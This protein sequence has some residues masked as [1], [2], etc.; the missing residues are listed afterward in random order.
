MDTIDTGLILKNIGNFN[1]EDFD[2]RLILHKTVYVLKSFGLDLGYSYGWYL[3]GTYSP[4][5][6]KVGFE[7]Q[8]KMKKIPK[9]DVK[10]TDANIQSKFDN[11]MKF[12]A[13]K[14]N[15]ACLL[16]IC[17]SI[18]YLYNMSFSKT[19]ILKMVENKKP[20][21]TQEQCLKMWNE[22]EGYGVLSV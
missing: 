1:M 11:F 20:N 19:E 17:A 22:L 15:D 14:K 16:E 6:A 13:D 7:L 2:G 4:E 18:C 8:D 12:M 5:L 10:F 9:I 3:H 21:F